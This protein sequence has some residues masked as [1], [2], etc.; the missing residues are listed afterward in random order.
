MTRMLWTLA[1]FS[2]IDMMRSR[3]LW[4]C[5]A[6]VVGV[7]AVALFA[8]ALAIT[9][10]HEVMLSA[11][12]ALARLA[13]IAIVMLLSASLL[14][15]E[16]QER[17]WLLGLAAPMSRSVW[18]LGK[19]LGLG[20]VAC[21]SAVLFA[22]PL[23]I[24]Q[25]GAST[26]GWAA[27]LMLEALLVSS[28]VMAAAL[29]FKQLPATLFASGVFYLAARVIG[30]VQMLNERAPLENQAAQGLTNGWLEV[31]GMLLPRLDLFTST[32]WLLEPQSWQPNSLGLVA[33]QAA[34][35]CAIVLVVGC[36]DL[37]RKDVA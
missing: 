21:V 1:R 6:G 23:M 26:L 20:A 33:G 18:I 11:V 14:V 2:V 16:I 30:L 36:I 4:L 13:C 9:E 35:Y 31:L 7:S 34:L 32:Q 10:R 24:L 37:T 27:S 17:T 29:A 3:W 15:R 5:L 12:A 28:L 25:P 19:W 22:I 8:G